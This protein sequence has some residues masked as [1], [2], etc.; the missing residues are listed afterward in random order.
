MNSQLEVTK[1]YLKY[2]NEL[3]DRIDKVLSSHGLTGGKSPLLLNDTSLLIT[4]CDDGNFYYFV[5][6]SAEIY[7]VY[8]SYCKILSTED[9]ERSYYSCSNDRLNSITYL[10]S[11]C[12]EKYRVLVSNLINLLQ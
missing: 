8:K 11:Q 10:P 2:M 4:I 7:S 5:G 9:G 1:D 12:V 6:S 3:S